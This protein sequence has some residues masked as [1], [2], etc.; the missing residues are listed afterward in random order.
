MR[1]SIPLAIALASATSAWS[2]TPASYAALDKASAAACAAASGFRNPIVHAPVRFADTS[3]IDARLVEGRWPQPHMKGR[4]GTM[5]CLYNRRARR[6]EVQ[7]A[8]MWQAK[9]AQTDPPVRDTSWRLTAIGGSAPTAST[10]ITLML[11]SDGH[12]TGT[13]GCNRYSARYVLNG[14]SLRVVPPFI[15]TGI[16]CPAAAMN[17]ER[18]YQAALQKASTWSLT[19]NGRLTITQQSGGTLSFRAE[20]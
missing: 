15:G 18:R 8:A 4:Q 17:L 5:L 20:R 11:G 7:E 14:A 19:P 3:G 16:A 9:I 10:P 12:A 6:A 2:A 1:R 13:S